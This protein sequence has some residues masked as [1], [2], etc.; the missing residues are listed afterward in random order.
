LLRI[1]GKSNG[2]IKAKLI[3]FHRCT[4]EDLEE[5]AT[6]T[7]DAAHTLK[8]ILDDPKR[9]LYCLD[10]QKLG[11]QLSIWGISQYDDYQ[12]IDLTIAPC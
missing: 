2:E 8:K 6:P 5:F 10:W 9:G 12:F 11:E 7:V 1:S 4:E 3:D